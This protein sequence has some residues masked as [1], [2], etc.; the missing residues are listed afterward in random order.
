MVAQLDSLK[1]IMAPGNKKKPLADR[2]SAKLMSFGLTEEEI[3]AI[4]ANL[5]ER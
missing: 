2:I 3:E 5:L 4:R 1:T